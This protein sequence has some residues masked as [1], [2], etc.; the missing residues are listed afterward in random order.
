MK[1]FKV[2]T[3]AV[4]AVLLAFSC[5][6]S[7]D[8][9]GRPQFEIDRE[10]ILDYL[11]DNGITAQEAPSGL[12]FEI[13]N[14]GGPDRATLATD[15]TEGLCMDDWENKFSQSSAKNKNLCLLRNLWLI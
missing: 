5:G 15:Y 9:N 4:L 7:D 12:F 6:S 13:I 10:L 1:Q 14:A 3:I 2:F 8:D 11:A